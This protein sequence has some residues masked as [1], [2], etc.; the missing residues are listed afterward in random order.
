MALSEE[1]QKLL[2]QMEAALAAEDPRLANALRGRRR[3]LSPR[4]MVMSILGFA[5]G[6]TVLVV[7][8]Q[9]HPLVSVLGFVL[10]LAATVAGVNSWQR[11]GS[12][13][14]VGADHS[15]A[16]DRPERNSMGRPDDW[17]GDD[18]RHRS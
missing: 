13:S 14:G 2:E 17:G 18:D 16:A 1:E 8:I 7:G 6:L 10:M 9:V 12:V 4:W 5:L 11:P 15:Q 3:P